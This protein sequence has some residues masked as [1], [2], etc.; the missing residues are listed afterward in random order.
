MA[1]LVSN[2][3]RSNLRSQRL[4][5]LLAGAGMLV[6]APVGVSVLFSTMDLGLTILLTG[7]GAAGVALGMRSIQQ[8]ITLVE[9]RTLDHL[10]DVF[11]EAFRGRDA[12]DVRQRWQT[13][14]PELR[15]YLKAQ[16]IVN[17][18]S[19]SKRDLKRLDAYTDV[20][21][22]KMRQMVMEYKENTDAGVG[23]IERDG[24]HE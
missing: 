24:S 1:A 7:F 19:T 14:K 21:I 16:G 23:D 17:A 15:K 6:M 9:E 12:L 5:K 11:E 8:S 18:P 13:V 2:A 3:V 22:P 4:P 10:D 20:E